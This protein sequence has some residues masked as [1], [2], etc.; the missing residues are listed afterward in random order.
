MDNTQGTHCRQWIQ[1]NLTRFQSI[2][3][4]RIDAPHYH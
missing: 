3:G 2:Q 1:R 4:Q